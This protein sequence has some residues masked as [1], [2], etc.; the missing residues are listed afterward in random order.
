MA[1]K[2]KYL[3]GEK[4]I[5]NIGLEYEIIGYGKEYSRRIVRFKSGYEVDVHTNNIKR[6]E[7]KDY[8]S[9][10]V[11]GVGI[12]GF[13]GAKSHFLYSRWKGMI[14]RCYNKNVKAYK[15]YGEKG[16]RVDNELLNFENYIKIIENLDNYEKLKESPNE[17]EI[18][19]DILSYG[20]KVYSKDSLKIVT[21]K[22][23]LKFYK[24]KISNIKV[25]M[26]DKNG[27]VL[28]SFNSISE[29]GKRTGVCISSIQKVIKGERNTAGG[30]YWQKK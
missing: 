3:I 19:K 13:K 27:I 1:T 22:E 26:I 4:F 24:D 2:T 10:T 8:Y 29:A 18:D 5:N 16:I 25:D 6:G 9:P 17:Y 23:N 28:N 14:D 12:V 15:H 30:Y 11:C 20:V 7:I 21:S